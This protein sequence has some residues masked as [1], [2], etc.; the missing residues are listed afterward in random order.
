MRAL[1]TKGRVDVFTHECLAVAPFR[2]NSGSTPRRRRS[3]FVLYDGRKELAGVDSF[4]ARPLRRTFKDD[5]DA[6]RGTT[7]LHPI[8]GFYAVSDVVES[9]VIA[10]TQK[11][12]EGGRCA[13]ANARRDE[14]F[15]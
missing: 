5:F 13:I 6:G 2:R 1:F 3:Q 15:P 11:L 9:K 12:Y 10:D 14:D 8:Y 4:A 7:V